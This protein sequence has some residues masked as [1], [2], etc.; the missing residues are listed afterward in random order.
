MRANGLESVRSKL[1]HWY[2]LGATGGLPVRAG[3]GSKLPVAPLYE[4][5]PVPKL[6]YSLKRAPVSLRFD[7]LNSP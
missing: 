2:H 6:E 4:A 1:E 3:T 7:N 5:I